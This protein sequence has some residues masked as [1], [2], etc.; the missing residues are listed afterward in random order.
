MLNKVVPKI[1]GISMTISGNDT[2]IFR[3]DNAF[4]GQNL[5][6]LAAPSGTHGHISER[7]D[8]TPLIIR[9]P[10]V[11]SGTVNHSYLGC[12]RE[13]VAHRVGLMYRYRKWMLQNIFGFK[14]GSIYHEICASDNGE[15]VLIVVS[16]P[17]GNSH[18]EGVDY[19]NMDDLELPL[20][21]KYGETRV[22]AID[23]ATLSIDAQAVLLAKTKV[24][25]TNHGGGSSTCLFLQKG[26][27]A[28]TVYSYDNKGREVRRDDTL[29]DSIPYFR[30]DWIPVTSSVADIIQHVEHA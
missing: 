1:M 4:R 13:C 6:T 19:R 10:S 14:A 12:M 9:F 15:D 24:L 2:D 25:I 8:K 18:V 30:T 7:V 27:T 28:I 26:S 5:P 16:L 22:K 17:I 3:L 29:Y 23:L 20:Q 11:L 21:Q